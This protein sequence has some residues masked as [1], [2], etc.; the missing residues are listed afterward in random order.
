MT[1]KELEEARGL[2]DDMEE[3]VANRHYFEIHTE[4][5]RLLAEYIRELERRV[6]PLP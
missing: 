2:V 3:C 5:A 4:H 1:P 6:A